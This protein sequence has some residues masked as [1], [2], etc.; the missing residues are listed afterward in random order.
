MKVNREIL[1]EVSSVKYL[2]RSRKGQ[3]EH[4]LN[5]F[6]IDLDK[7]ITKQKPNEIIMY[8]NAFEFVKFSDSFVARTTLWT[9]SQLQAA[10]R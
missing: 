3:L 8:W 5:R 1:K 9:G 6:T 10:K 4:F 7:D 2:K